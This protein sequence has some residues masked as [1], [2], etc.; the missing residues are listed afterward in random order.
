MHLDVLPAVPNREVGGSN[1]LITDREVRRWL[2]SNPAGY[3][4][5]FR[6]RMRDELFA[7]RAVQA[8]RLDVEDVPEWQVKTTLQQ[9]VQALKRHRDIYFADRLDDRPPSIIITTL[10]ALAYAGAGELYD[11]LRN[12]TASMGDHLSVVDGKWVLANPAQAD[13]NFADSWA[14]HPSRANDFFEWLTHAEATFD[15]FGRRSGL[16]HAVPLLEKAFGDRFVKAAARG[17]GTTAY[18]TSRSGKLYVASGGA[19]AASVTSGRKVRS[20]GFAGGTKS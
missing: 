11:V 7:E 5:W 9:A 1:I 12:V 18:E 10:A 14:T 16:H 3:A 8:K 6:S 15:E 17:M 19:L 2:D 20:H 13:E 4:E